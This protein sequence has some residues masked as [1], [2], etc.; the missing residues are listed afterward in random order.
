[1]A[2]GS[3]YK[4][5]VVSCGGMS[6]VVIELRRRS[7]NAPFVMIEITTGPKK[8]EREYPN[9]GWQLGIG[10]LDGSCE[11]CGRRFLYKPGD[12]DH[13][14]RGCWGDDQAL[15]SRRSADPDRPRSSWDLKQLHASR[16]RT[17]S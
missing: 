16:E 6:G 13:T 17:T 2:K 15:A 3:F 10:T 1:M 11:R 5:D 9:A 7:D 12:V 14:C 8:G 4:G